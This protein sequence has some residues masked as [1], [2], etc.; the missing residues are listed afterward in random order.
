MREIGPRSSET[1]PPLFHPPPPPAQRHHQVRQERSKVFIYI[2]VCT[3]VP[4]GACL[5]KPA[6]FG[7]GTGGRQRLGT[8]GPPALEPQPL[9]HWGLDVGLTAPRAVL[10]L[11]G[12]SRAEDWGEIPRCIRGTWPAPWMSLCM[13]LILSALETQRRSGRS[14]GAS[15]T[16]DPD[17]TRDLTRHPGLSTLGGR[18]RRLLMAGD[19]A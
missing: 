16:Q 14:W 15:V 7:P 8:L 18:A 1:R 9:S 2:L 11:D 4:Q 12:G 19:A 13:Q 3:R 10:L 6:P 17:I 5:C